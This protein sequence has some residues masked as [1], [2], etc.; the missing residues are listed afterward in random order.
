[1]L[2]V[3]ATDVF[4]GDFVSIIMYMLFKKKSAGYVA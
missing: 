1:M 4:S 2:F 3:G